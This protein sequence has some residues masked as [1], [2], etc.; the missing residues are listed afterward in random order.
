MKPT[1][2]ADAAADHLAFAPNIHTLRLT[3]RLHD[4]L[5]HPGRRRLVFCLLAEGKRGLR[6]KDAAAAAGIKPYEASRHFMKLN[7]ASLADLIPNSSD[8]DDRTKRFGCSELAL[9]WYG[10]TAFDNPKQ[11]LGKPSVAEAE[12]LKA[13]TRVHEA[14]ACLPRLQILAHLVKLPG[15]KRTGELADDLSTSL[16]LTR[17]HLRKLEGAHLI[18]NEVRRAQFNPEQ[19]SDRGLQSWYFITEEGTRQL[20]LLDGFS[21]QTKAIARR[22]RPSSKHAKRIPA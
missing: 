4:A 9:R 14:L 15:G 10:S 21:I 12:A 13:D 8:M 20:Q 17:L 2:R 1:I 7:Q 3:Q 6:V 5:R 18:R 19:G 16:E 22:P 11:L